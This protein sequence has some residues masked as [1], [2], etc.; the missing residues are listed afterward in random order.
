MI[1]APSSRKRARRRSKRPKETRWM[2][3]K[4]KLRDKP[5]KISELR[6]Q[7]NARKRELSTQTKE[8]STHPAAI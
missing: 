8:L 2:K 1:L 3:N 5:I 6:S 7:R 4:N